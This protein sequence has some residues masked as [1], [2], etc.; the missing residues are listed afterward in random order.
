MKWLKGSDVREIGTVYRVFEL[1]WRRSGVLWQKKLR[2]S[3]VNIISALRTAHT[4][5]DDV[6]WEE[7]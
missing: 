3:L 2:G 6:G 1:F 4:Y 7:K 5:C